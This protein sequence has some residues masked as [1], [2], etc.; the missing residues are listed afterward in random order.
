MADHQNPAEVVY[1]A[2]AGDPGGI[3][4]RLNDGKASVLPAILLIAILALAGCSAGDNTKLAAA[5]V[6]E[7]HRLL[8]AGEFDRIYAD[9]SADL[10]QPTSQEDFVALLAAVRRKLGTTKSSSQ[11][12]WNINYNTSGRYI[13]LAYAT[14]YSDGEAAEQFVYRIEGERALL[15]G[16]HVNSNALIVK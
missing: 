10:K 6:T 3:M 2:A 7:F 1:P 8:D 16:Y 5:G 11:Q 12:G 15:A 13:T 14:V 9:A 4:I